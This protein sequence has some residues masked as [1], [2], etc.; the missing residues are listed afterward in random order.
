ME[1]FG[2]TKKHKAEQEL[3]RV[4]LGSLAEQMY[5]GRTNGYLGRTKGL[6]LCKS[7]TNLEGGRTRRLRS[8]NG[9]TK[10]RCRLQVGSSA[11][12]MIKELED[13]RFR[14]NNGAGRL[15]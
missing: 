13:A 2:R 10:E 3:L 1:D 11:E 5:L 7:R 15:G 9:R 6:V 8:L 12:Q 4:L 14:P